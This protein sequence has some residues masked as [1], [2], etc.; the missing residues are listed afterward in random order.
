MRALKITGTALIAVVLVVALL[1]VVGIPTGF[2]SAAI[3]N[4][5]E[6]QTGYH[7]TIAG[8]ARIGLWPSL[9][10]SLSDVTLQDPKDHDGSRRITVGK[11]QADMTLSSAWSGHP[12]IKQL[13]VTDPVVH[14]PLLRE[15]THE[16]ASPARPA[17]TADDR[18]AVTIERVRIVNGTMVFANKRDRVENRIDRIEADAA[19]GADRKVKISG[20]A[21]AGEHPVKFA[22]TAKAPA[23]PIARQNVPVDLTLDAPDLLHAP[24]SAKAD[25][26][27]NGSLL[28]F[29]GVTGKLGDGRFT[30]WASVDAASKPLVKVDL[31][32]QRL[33]IPLSNSS[34]SSGT[35]PW[36]TA[37]IDFIGL[38][39]LD[40]NITVSAAARRS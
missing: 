12:R 21:R 16:I 7:L 29:N 24:L 17:A 13:T 26:R 31:D 32:F 4:R 37:P 36:S 9:N 35:Q 20:S 11:L 5:I 8:A 30:G 1:L 15:R 28:T 3:Q 34:E 40:A 39:Y 27:F 23:R 22:I 10:V 33:N 25:V 38:N 2:L 14:L 6:R 18:D 19:I